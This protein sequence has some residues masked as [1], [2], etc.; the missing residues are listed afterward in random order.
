MTNI[1]KVIYNQ[2]LMTLV[3]YF[4][5]SYGPATE[6]KIIPSP[7]F[8]VRLGPIFDVTREKALKVL[9]SSYHYDPHYLLAATTTAQGVFMDWYLEKI[10]ADRFVYLSALFDMEGVTEQLES[11][12]GRLGILGEDPWH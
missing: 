6:E 1:E 12:P 3:G 11:Y 10:L 8:H 5:R 4:P 7:L 9:P 2:P